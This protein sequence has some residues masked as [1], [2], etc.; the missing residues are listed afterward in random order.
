[1][2]NLRSAAVESLLKKLYFQELILCVCACLLAG[3]QDDWCVPIGRTS[4][5]VAAVSLCHGA[6][7]QCHKQ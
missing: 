2:H 5:F 6:T 4:R 1:M 3:V 7:Q